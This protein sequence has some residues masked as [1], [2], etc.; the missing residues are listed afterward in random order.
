LIIPTALLEYIGFEWSF[1]HQSP[2]KVNAHLRKVKSR[3]LDTFYVA[4]K[5]ALDSVSLS[6]IKAWFALANYSV[7]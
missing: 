4:L 7:V 1:P 6:D 2:S 3:T 5:D